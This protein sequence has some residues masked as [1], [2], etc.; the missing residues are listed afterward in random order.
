MMDSMY[1]NL[2][3]ISLHGKLGAW[4]AVHASLKRSNAWRLTKRDGTGRN[5][6]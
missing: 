5:A 6:K 2:T 3:A 1:I 4:F